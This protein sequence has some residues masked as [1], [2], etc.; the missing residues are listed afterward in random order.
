MWER[1][2]VACAGT[3]FGRGGCFGRDGCHSQ[4]GPA[5]SSLDRRRDWCCGDRRPGCGAGPSL[6]CSCTALLGQGLLFGCWS[7]RAQ[8]GFCAVVPGGRDGRI[9]TARGRCVPALERSTGQCALLCPL[10]PE[11]TVAGPA[12]GPTPA[13]AA[14]AIS[15]SESPRTAE[16]PPPDLTWEPTAQ[17][18]A[19]PSALCRHPQSP[20]LRE[21]PLCSAV[22]QAL[23][24]QLRFPP[25]PARGQPLASAPAVVSW[26]RK[27]AR[28]G[29][30]LLEPKAEGAD[31][32]IK[33]VM[34]P[35]TLELH[36]CGGPG[37]YPWLR[38]AIPHSS[39]SGMSPSS[40]HQ[41]SPQ[42]CPQ[43]CFPAPAFTRDAHLA[44]VTGRWQGPPL[45]VLP[46]SNY[47][48]P[49]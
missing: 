21:R 42:G 2:C 4:C 20:Q 28:A 31:V 34:G 8:R 30:T 32:C 17:T 47:H 35:L 3:M 43:P 38:S 36:F 16:V 6:P 48:A 23:R 41:S 5:V 15:P 39:P 24:V 33:A 37:F 27:P 45:S 1:A 25:H 12:R 18:L 29:H 14:S 46:A 19:W 44:G 7:R 26:T 13:M 22:P 11:V 9:P 10:P 40:Q 49:L